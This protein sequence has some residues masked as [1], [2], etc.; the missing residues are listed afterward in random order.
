MANSDDEREEEQVQQRCRRPY[1]TSGGL[2]GAPVIADR[3]RATFGGGID[4]VG[5]GS[6]VS[7]AAGLNQGRSQ[8]QKQAGLSK[9]FSR[10]RF[11][12][13]KRRRKG[14][15][16]PSCLRAL[17]RKEP[18]LRT[19]RECKCTCLALDCLTAPTVLRTCARALPAVGGGSIGFCLN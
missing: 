12:L 15:T 9:D 16:S 11:E 19:R 3:G 10:R 8:Q 14:R 6:L 7:P 5:G 1:S 13:E 4:C 17:L 2:L 18:F